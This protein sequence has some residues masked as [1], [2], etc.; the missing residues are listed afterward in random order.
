MSKHPNMKARDHPIGPWLKPYSTCQSRDRSINKKD[1][2]V[3]LI[4]WINLKNYKRSLVRHVFIF[5]SKGGKR[6]L[7]I[8]T[9]FDKTVQHLFELA[10]ELVTEAFTD[11]YSFGFRRGKCA[12]MHGGR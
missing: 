3:R 8:P 7:G 10:I 9:I 6:L 5:E 12:H 1:S 11:K 4:S 2:L